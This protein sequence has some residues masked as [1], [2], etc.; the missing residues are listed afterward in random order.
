MKPTRTFFGLV[1]IAIGI[2]FLLINLGSINADDLSNFVLFWP[3]LLVLFGL[4]MMFT[5]NW[6]YSVTAILSILLIAFLALADP[7][8]WQKKEGTERK[9]IIHPNIVA[10]YDKTIENF[11]FTLDLGAAI[12]NVNNFDDSN[13]D[14]LIKGN[15]GEGILGLEENRTNENHTADLHIKEKTTDQSLSTIVNPNKKRFMDLEIS[16]RIPTEFT[17]NSGASKLDLDFSNIDLRKLTVNSG[18]SAIKVKLGNKSDNLESEINCGASD[19][20]IM[21]PKD[22][23]IKIESN[24]VLLGKDLTDLDL[25]QNKNSYSSRDYDSKTKKLSIKLSSGVS[26]LSVKQY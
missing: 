18:A 10:V 19:I 1:I 8:D 24:S 3:A 14:T 7:Y 23:G 5:S 21:I 2:I 13:S 4:A 16:D 6:L 15:Y 25:E 12:I 9:E 20:S 22:F 26:K 11:K 17:I